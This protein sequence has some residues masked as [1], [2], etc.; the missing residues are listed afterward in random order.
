[1]LKLFALALV[2]LMAASAFGQNQTDNS[3]R[4]KSF[5]DALA[6]KD[7]AAAENYF[8]DDVKSKI[9]AEELTKIWDSLTAQVGDFKAQGKVSKTQKDNLEIFLIPCEFEKANLDI[10]TAFD[11]QGKIAGLF[12]LPLNARS[13]NARLRQSKSFY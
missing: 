10:Q 2:A 1:M 12:F 6:K 8:N 9:S 3:A 7:F 4:A 11:A 13:A 5:I